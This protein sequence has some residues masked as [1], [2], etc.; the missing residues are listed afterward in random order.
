MRWNNKGVEVDA[1]GAQMKIS[2][3][4]PEVT[5]SILKIETPRSMYS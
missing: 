2:Q 4:R 3:R 5:T 1:A